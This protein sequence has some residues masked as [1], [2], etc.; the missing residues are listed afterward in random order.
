MK[1]RVLGVEPCHSMVVASRFG[2]G[3]ESLLLSRVWLS[4]SSFIA[5][6]REPKQQP[7]LTLDGLLYSLV[8]FDCHL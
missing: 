1:P 8:L 2:L 3:V 6:H 7:G 5:L 4:K